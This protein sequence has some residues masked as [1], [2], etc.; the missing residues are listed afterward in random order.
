MNYNIDF[1]DAIQKEI[2]MN[3]MKAM[4]RNSNPEPQATYLC[5]QLDDARNIADCLE[6]I[7][8]QV[9]KNNQQ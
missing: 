3:A 6:Q 8:K 9:N 5:N 2:L 4:I 1:R 7:L